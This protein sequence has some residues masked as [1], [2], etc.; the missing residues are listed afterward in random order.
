MNQFNSKNT[1]TEHVLSSSNS[2]G[3]SETSVVSEK[4]TQCGFE[5]PEKLIEIWFA[6]PV[7]SDQEVPSVPDLR[8]QV[9]RQTWEAMLDIV[10]CKILSVISNEHA[11]AYLLR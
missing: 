11:D 3:T 9:D 10:R 6:P 7:K 2:D 4:V 8:R 1:Q 5:G